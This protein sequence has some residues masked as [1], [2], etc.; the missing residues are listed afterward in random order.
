MEN[1]HRCAFDAP[2]GDSLSRSCRRVLA[3]SGHSLSSYIR[4]QCSCLLPTF[5]S[6]IDTLEALKQAQVKVTIATS[7]RRHL[8]EEVLDHHNLSHY[9]SLIVGAQDVAN[10]KPHPES[11]HLTLKQMSTDKT[12]AVVIGDS[13]YDLDMARSAGVDAIGVTTGIHTKEV[14]AGSQPTHIVRG[15]DEVLPIILNGKSR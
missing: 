6:L 15:L 10:H 14:L 4:R 1:A 2:N 7:K 13:T 8:V 11:V 9:F 5:S 12:D 3:G